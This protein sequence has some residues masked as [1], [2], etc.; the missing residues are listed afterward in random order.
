MSA[1]GPTSRFPLGLLDLF[2]VKQMGS[3]PREISQLIQPSIDVL[4]MVVSAN[5]DDTGRQLAINIGAAGG[6]VPYGFHTGLTTLV[7]AQN[8]CAFITHWGIQAQILGVGGQLPDSNLCFV[9]ALGGAYFFSDR[10][11]HVTIAGSAVRQG[12]SRGDPNCLIFVP[13]GRNV[14]LVTDT[15]SIGA[16]GGDCA[17]E[18]NLRYVKMRI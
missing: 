10:N 15:D 6:T 17:I 13:P 16:V 11:N 9:D 5:A 1:V 12:Y 4:K 14:W 2:G 7:T 18:F 3:Y 8:E